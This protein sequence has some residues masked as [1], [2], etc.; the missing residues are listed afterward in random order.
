VKVNE[1]LARGVVD[2]VKRV[3]I[4]DAAGGARVATVDGASFSD[5]PELLVACGGDHT[6]IEF[7]EAIAVQGDLLAPI[8]SPRKVICLGQNYRDHVAEGGRTSSP[9]YPDLFPKWASS[10]AGPTDEVSLPPESNVVDF[11]SELAIVIGRRGRRVNRSDVADVV[12]GYTAANDGSVRDFQFHTQGRMAGKAWDGL[13]PIGPR[14]VP[15]DHIGGIE[16]DLRIVGRLNGEVMQS[17]QTGMLIFSVVDIVVYL[18][19]FLTLAPGDV[20]LTG[21]PAGVG[22]FREPKRMLAD[23]DVFEVEI[24]G[25][26]TL[27]NRYVAEG[28]SQ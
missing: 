16:P 4:L 19:T 17:S 18:S 26:G 10:L 6:R 5:I 21:T 20:I 8:G 23:G 24:E 1:G 2:G 28:R 13:T 9:P 12:F 15:A 7:G 3:L 14:V 11:E 25:I 27:R 22:Y